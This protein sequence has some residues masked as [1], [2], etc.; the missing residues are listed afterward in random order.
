MRQISTKM[1][2]TTMTTRM[3]T[4]EK[5]DEKEGK[6]DTIIDPNGLHSKEGASLVT[7]RPQ[8]LRS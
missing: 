2:T 5:E 7:H 1:Q 3:N 8:R 6:R 4:E